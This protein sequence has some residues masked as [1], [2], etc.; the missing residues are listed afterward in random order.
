M[1]KVYIPTDKEFNYKEC[2]QLFKKNKKKLRETFSFKEVIDGTFFYS[3]FDDDR[4]LGCIYFYDKLGKRYI[5]SFGT[6]H[7][8][9]ENIECL[10]LSLTWFNSDIYAITYEKTAKLC[11]LRAGF[12]KI[13]DNTFIYERS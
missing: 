6:R 2:K 5:A 3:F 11:L 4:F 8:H 1:I 9:K 12:K 13:D 10:K 7:H